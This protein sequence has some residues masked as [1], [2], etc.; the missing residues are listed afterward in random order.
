MIAPSQDNGDGRFLENVKFV[1]SLRLVIEQHPFLLTTSLENEQIRS[2]NPNSGM[3]LLSRIERTP[4][5]F[6]AMNSGPAKFPK[7]CG[8][9]PSRSSSACSLFAVF[10]CGIL[11]LPIQMFG[12]VAKL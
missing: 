6:R 4:S 1:I 11:V 5:F 7:T 9:L 10:P 2:N 12:L 3:P 8:N